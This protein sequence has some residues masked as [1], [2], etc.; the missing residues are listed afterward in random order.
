MRTEARTGAAARRGTRVV[1]ACTGALALAALLAAPGRLP[2][3]NGD[4]VGISN[5]LAGREITGI[6]FDQ[7]S[8]SF[9]A[10]GRLTGK[11]YQVR[12]D[13]SAIDREIDN[14]H[15]VGVIPNFIL[16][17]GLTYRPLT[18][19]LFILAQE[20]T[21]YRIREVRTADGVEVPEG[22]FTVVPPDPQTSTLR[23]IAY[24]TIAR[25]FWY[26]DSNND[27]IVQTDLSGQVLGTRHLPGDDPRETTLRGE[28]ISFELFEVA[29]NA[30]EPRLYLTYGDIFR[31]NPSRILQ[32]NPETGASTGIEVP[33]GSVPGTISAI[34]GFRVGPQRRFAVATLEGRI[35]Q[36]E[37]VLPQPVPPSDL[38][39]TLTLGNKVDLQ[40]N[41]HG[42]GTSGAYG[43]EIVI[44]RNGV[45][46]TT[47]PGSSTSYIDATPSQG[48][49]TYSLRAAGT[50]GGSL[51]PVSFP[52]EICVGTGGLVRWSPFGGVS[53]YDLATDP[54]TGEVFVTDNIGQG[55]GKILRY[56]RDFQLLGEVPSPW[57]R[58]GAIAFLPSVTLQGQSFTNL[59]AVG[60]TDGVL[61]KLMDVAGAEKTTIALEGITNSFPGSLTYDSRR[62]RFIY[63]NSELLAPEIIVA[64][65][66]GRKLGTCTPPSVLNLPLTRQ[67]IA[68]DPLQDTLLVCFEDGLV[69]E[70]YLGSCVPTGFEIG[71]SCLGEGFAGSGFVGGMELAGNTL[72]VS[73]R[74]SRALFQV[75]LFPAGPPFIRGDFDRNSQVNITDAVGMADY[76]FRSGPAPECPDA[77][78]SN[79]DGTLDVSD[80]L[81]LLIHLFLQGTLP[82][83]S[84]EPG[85]D[86]TNRDGIG[87]NEED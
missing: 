75:F 29:P 45:A 35:A 19:T 50:A 74:E 52:C 17:W 86:P 44:L 15:G 67:G 12:L 78:D 27:V 25:A 11:L 76:L 4:V 21:S 18:R 3:A 16:T 13:L 77:A 40:W 14:P 83:P 9:W 87:C 32:I 8:N 33:L 22:A 23:G 43:G 10:A 1:G 69:R 39:C 58:P 51:S 20:G 7:T 2:A 30:Y 26:I 66:N 60:R 73:G 34:Q 31:K 61:V 38:K 28:G 41:N 79:D 57:D 64:D 24:D 84:P 53:P 62:Q 82:A 37:Q 85:Q 71:L 49:S 48:Q 56:S 42:D 63:T 6:T 80:P 65:S 36:V 5:V 47:V 72:L 81:F 70:L 54:A 46:F 55:R 68:Y 59:L